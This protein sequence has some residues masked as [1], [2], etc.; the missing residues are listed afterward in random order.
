MSTDQ[1]TTL[2]DVARLHESAVQAVAR[3]EVDPPKKKRTR[4]KNK[5]R[6]GR[7]VTTKPRA[8]VWAK[9]KEVRRKGEWM[10]P[11]T[12]TEVMVGQPNS[13]AMRLPDYRGQA[14]PEP[15]PDKPAAPR[16]RRV[17]G[18]PPADAFTVEIV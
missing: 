7:L 6:N 11:I 3:G 10:V 9:A 8:D 17:M 18:V 12:E 5:S 13:A 16:G 15:E 14:Q 2:P 4:G 1:E